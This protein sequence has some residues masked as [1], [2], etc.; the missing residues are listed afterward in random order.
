MEATERAIVAGGSDGLTV[1]AG[2]LYLVGTVRSHVIDEPELRDP[3][4]PDVEPGA[5]RR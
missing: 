1:V 5:D 4:P 3:P 2:S